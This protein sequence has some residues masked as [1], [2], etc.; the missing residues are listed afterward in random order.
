MPVDTYNV[1]SVRHARR[2]ERGPRTITEEEL[3]L[4][5][6]KKD[7][8]NGAYNR[9]RLANERRRIMDAWGKYCYALLNT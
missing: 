7:P 9:A 3:Y 4:F 1:N 6:S 8:N 2:L 5:H